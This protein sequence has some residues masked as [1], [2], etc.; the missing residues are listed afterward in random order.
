MVERRKHKR[1][2]IRLAVD[3]EANGKRLMLYTRDISIGGVF[4]KANGQ[5]PPPVGAVVKLIFSATPSAEEPY[6]LKARVQRSNDSGIALTFVDF[7]L[8]DL[9]FIEGMLGRV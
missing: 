9:G 3:L 7:G 1:E 5:P 6:T 4:L 2:S 8:D